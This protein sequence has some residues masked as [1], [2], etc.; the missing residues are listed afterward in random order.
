MSKR[1]TPL[2]TDK[3]VDLVTS[4]VKNIPRGLDARTVKYW[5]NNSKQMKDAL[6]KVLADP[7]ASL[8]KPFHH[9]G[10]A[11]HVI[12]PYK[13]SCDPELVFLTENFNCSKG[14]IE[15]MHCAGRFSTSNQCVVLELCLESERVTNNQIFHE[16]GRHS[17]F[18]I[19]HG[20]YALAAILKDHLM[21]G[22]VILELSKSTAQ[23][24]LFVEH[25]GSVYK[26]LMDIDDGGKRFIMRT[27]PLS[28]K[29]NCSDDKVLL[30]Q[31]NPFLWYD[32]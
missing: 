12:S 3:F 15:L 29:V 26:L 25:A 2:R 19:S 1:R 10:S 11:K 23:F 21:M 8:D 20:F 28:S 4:V 13:I 16:Y 24:A 5:H 9:Y 27:V 31:S 18:S 32:I 22:D 7:E 17:V 6:Q 30:L 14:F